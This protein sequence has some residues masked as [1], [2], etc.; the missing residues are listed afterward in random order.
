MAYDLNMDTVKAENWKREV[1]AELD[2]VDVLLKKVAELCQETLGEDDTMMQVIYN[3][4][5][6]L[7][8]TWTTLGNTLKEVQ[9]EFGN[10]I[11]TVSDVVETGKEKMEK[12]RSN[13]GF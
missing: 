4:G 8:T 13:I 12:Y 6:E 9:G 5:T 10:I 1:D 2:S 7:S 3:V 11:K